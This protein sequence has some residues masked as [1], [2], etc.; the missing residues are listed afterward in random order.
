MNNTVAGG[1]AISELKRYDPDGFPSEDG[2]N[3][4]A[5]EVLEYIGGLRG[6]LEGA[7]RGEKELSMERV[8]IVKWLDEIV[9]SG[10]GDREYSLLERMRHAV[11]STKRDTATIAALECERDELRQVLQDARWTF[12]AWKALSDNNSGV[13]DECE[14]DDVLE[15]WQKYPKA[16]PDIVVKIDAALAARVESEAQVTEGGMR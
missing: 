11:E 1:G 7:L 13:A 5:Y 2:T 3:M 16:K 4:D 15:V 12:A 10:D 6:E 9:F 8:E 14:V